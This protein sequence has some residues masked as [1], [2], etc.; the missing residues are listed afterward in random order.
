DQQPS[1]R[2]RRGSLHRSARPRRRS[3]ALL[4][5]GGRRP[6]GL[7]AAAARGAVLPR[8]GARRVVIGPWLPPGLWA[9]V[10]LRVRAAFR[11]GWER[12][13]T[14]SGALT[15]VAG[16]L[17]LG[18]WFVPLLWAPGIRAASAGWVDR[19]GPFGLL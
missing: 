7:L 13:R 16:L 14:P 1:A 2:R 18:S 10:R 9:V 6:P 4:G 5:H 15:A 8:H 12:V 11:D 3:G 19:V 17:F